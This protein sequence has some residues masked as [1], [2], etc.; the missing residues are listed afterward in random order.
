ME[1]PA[2]E[3]KLTPMR[4]S[5]IHAQITRVV[6]ERLL[7]MVNCRDFIESQGIKQEL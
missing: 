6:R 2:K 4:L 1:K 5:M 3:G 7:P